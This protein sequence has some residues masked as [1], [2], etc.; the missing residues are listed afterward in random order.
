[1]TFVAQVICAL[2]R[3]LGEFG[4]TAA[5]QITGTWPAK[6]SPWEYIHW[7]RMEVLVH[8]RVYHYWVSPDQRYQDPKRQ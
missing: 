7:H 2:A 1:M 8:G 4:K 5:N 3:E 6:R